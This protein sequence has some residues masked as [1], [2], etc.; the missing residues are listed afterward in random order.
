MSI[1]VSNRLWSLIP[2]I[3]SFLITHFLIC[4]FSYYQ[5]WKHMAWYSWLL[6]L[7]LFPISYSSKTWSIRPYYYY[8]VIIFIVIRSSR[9]RHHQRR[10][11]ARQK[12]FCSLESNILKK[13]NK[14]VLSKFWVY[15]FV[16]NSS[17]KISAQRT[18]LMLY[19][20]SYQRRFQ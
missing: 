9:I 2:R 6:L 19:R 7:S 1:F 17:I 4:F 16:L 15:F 12:F 3:F 18:I 13:F 20:L 5:N 8:A 14:Q 10:V 11:R